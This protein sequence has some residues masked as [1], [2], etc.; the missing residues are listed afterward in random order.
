[1]IG[2]W[3]ELLKI[4]AII[5]EQGKTSKFGGYSIFSEKKNKG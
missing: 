1:V 2:K 5:N 4:S 3:S